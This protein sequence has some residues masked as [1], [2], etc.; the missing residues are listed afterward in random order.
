MQPRLQQRTGGNGG[1]AFS[2]FGNSTPGIVGAA[3][4]AS[5]AT[6]ING[7]TAT[8]QSTATGSS[9][10]AQATAQTNFGS[11]NS[12]QTMATSQVSGTAPA[13]AL[14]QVGSALPF[15]IR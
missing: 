15:L 3:N 1:R 4:A 8:A 6:T 2:P 5:S 13:I 7:N 9:G 12:V 11:V 14:A 10:Q